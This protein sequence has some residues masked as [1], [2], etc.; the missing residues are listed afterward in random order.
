[1]SDQ[2]T[3]KVGIVL[4]STSDYETLK[5]SG[6]FKV[7]EEC[8]VPCNVAVAS[9]HRNPRELAQHCEQL[10]ELG[11]IVFIAGAGMAAA[12]PGTIC[13]HF[14]GLVPV[15]GVPL[16][17]DAVASMQLMPPGRPVHVQNCD[18]PG[19]YNAAIGAVQILAVGDPRL[20]ERFAL[21][22]ERSNKQPYIGVDQIEKAIENSKKK[23]A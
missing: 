3:Y 10:R 5:K 7:F 9:A 20:A 6:A 2:R 12:L 13:A 22:M 8:E 14:N 19:F 4:G 18:G 17:K 23:E 1:M 15:I 11:V 21:F 16:G